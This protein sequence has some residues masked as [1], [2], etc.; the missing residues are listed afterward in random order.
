VNSTDAWNKVTSKGD[1][2]DIDQLFLNALGMRWL[3][4]DEISTISPY[5]LG[6]LDSYL[7]RACCR[8]LYAKDP[9]GHKRPFGGI[10]IVFAGD[11]WQ[12]PPV[13]SSS[14]FSNPFLGGYSVEEQRI[15][16]MFWNRNDRDSIKGVYMLTQSMR[17]KDEWL[18]CLLEADRY[19]RESFEMY[20]F[21]HGLPTRHTG[22]WVPHRDGPTCGN[23]QCEELGNAVWE[24][25]WLR[26]AATGMYTHMENWKRR[27]EAEC[28]ICKARNS[29]AKA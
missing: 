10:N 13:C 9:T 21:V 24:E 11:F 1:E 28:D 23:Q 15:F 19:G 20:C 22:S 8:H 26:C 12:L 17:T 3:I 7:R 14:L 29:L 2:G 27:Q 5:L 4:L 16:K 6:L 18:Q 25:Q